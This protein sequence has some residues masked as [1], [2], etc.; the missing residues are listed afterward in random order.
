MGTGMGCTGQQQCAATHS[1]V[2]TWLNHDHANLVLQQLLLQGLERCH[3]PFVTWKC[4]G[5]W[6]G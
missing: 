6:D 1:K 5:T 2:H 4:E 3:L